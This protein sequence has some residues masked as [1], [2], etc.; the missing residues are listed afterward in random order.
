MDQ[1]RGKNVVMVSSS[2]E[3]DEEYDD[4]DDDDEDDDDDDDDNDDDD[5]DDEERDCNDASESDD[6]DVDDSSL[7]DKVVSLLQEGKDIKSLKLNECKAYLRNHGLRIAGN[8]DVCVSRITEHWRLKYGSGYMLYP[9]SSFTINCTGD[10]CTGDVVLFRQNVYEKFNKVIRHGKILGNR[11]IAGRVVKESYGAAKQQHTFT[12]EVLWS[13]GF[14]KLPPLSPLLVKGRNLYKQKTFRQRWKNE[15]D[16]IE[17]LREKHKRGAAARSKRASKN[18][19]RGCIANESEGNFE[20][21]QRSKRASKNRKRSCIAIESE[22]SKRQHEIHNKKGSKPGRSCVVDEIRHRDG[23]RQANNFQP[24]VA[25]SS[26]QEEIWKK[27]ASSRAST[28]TRGSYQYAEINSYQVPVYPLYDSYPESAH[29][30]H[31]NSQSRNVPSE[32]FHHNRGLIPH[33]IGI[34]P[35]RP[36]VGEF[37]TTSQLLLSNDKRTYTTAK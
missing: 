22:G 28:Y 3:E 14:R 27:N 4:V 37:T 7:C 35:P 31:V 18:R 8:R 2:E 26:T 20:L 1:T 15:P 25:T 9:K 29:R 13:T 23:S 5:E 12:V 16:R 36:R 34:P 30:Y 21:Q 6:N 17:V 10:V 19:K 32:F 11:T 33:M 24:Q